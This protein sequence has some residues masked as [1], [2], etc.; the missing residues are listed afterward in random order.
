MDNAAL[1]R[2]QDTCVRT[3]ASGLMSGDDTIPTAVVPKAHSGVRATSATLP[4]IETSGCPNSDHLSFS[5]FSYTRMNE[6]AHQTGAGE[7]GNCAGVF[8]AFLRCLCCNVEHRLGSGDAGGH[9]R[10]HLLRAR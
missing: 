9:D 7:T 6:K 4:R 1:K 5:P 3:K 2:A 10:R 8:H